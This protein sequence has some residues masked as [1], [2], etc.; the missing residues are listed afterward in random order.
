MRSIVETIEKVAPFC[1]PTCLLRLLLSLS[2]LLLGVACSKR[3]LFKGNICS[4]DT[5]QAFKGEQSPN[6]LPFK[7]SN[8]VKEKKKEKNTVR[9]QYLKGNFHVQCKTAGQR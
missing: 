3:V 1:I 5:P 4:L 7:N 2:I 9:K 8:K 6:P